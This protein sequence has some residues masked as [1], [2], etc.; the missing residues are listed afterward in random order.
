MP[1]DRII[2][3]HFVGFHQEDGLLIDGHGN[4][5]QQEIWDLMEEVV[6][7]ASVKGIILERDEKLPSIESLLEELSRARR[8]LEKYCP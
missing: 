1:A 7:F 5:T 2:Q 8:L 4:S 6:K 3:L